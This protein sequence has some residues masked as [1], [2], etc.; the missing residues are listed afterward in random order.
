M[1]WF[2]I[3]VFFIVFSILIKNKITKMEISGTLF[4]ILSITLISCFSI[5]IGVFF[6]IFS[7]K[8]TLWVMV[9]R[10]MLY[11]GAFILYYHVFS[12]VVISLLKNEKG[13]IDLIILFMNIFI[14]GGLLIGEI[15]LKILD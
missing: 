4:K 6:D 7:P 12:E 14:G 9:I 10:F 11:C 5:F 3:P 13:S 2:L 8:K 15:I 1:T